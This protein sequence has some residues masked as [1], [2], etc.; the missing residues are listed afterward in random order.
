MEFLGPINPLGRRT[1]AWY[2]IIET[3]YLTRWEEAMTVMDCTVATKSK[4]IFENIVTRFGCPGILMSEQGSHFINR[5]VR[6]LT[7]EFEMQHQKS[8]PYHL[9]E[10]GTVE[11]FNKIFETALTKV[12]N[13]NRVESDLKILAVLWAYRTTC[14]RLTG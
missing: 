12:C 6:A 4:F 3:N 14:K 13:T 10:N 1:S 8:T 7:E 9:Q 2:I 5:T 11:A